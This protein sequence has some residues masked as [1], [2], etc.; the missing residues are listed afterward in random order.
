[1]VR[2][3]FT[4]S[5]EFLPAT[6]TFWCRPT[7]DFE[8]VTA[9]RSQFAAHSQVALAVAD[10]EAEDL[11]LLLPYTRKGTPGISVCREEWDAESIFEVGYFQADTYEKD[12][13][14]TRCANLRCRVVWGNSIIFRLVGEF[15]PNGTDI[16]K[17]DCVRAAQE[18]VRF[19]NLEVNTRTPW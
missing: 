6:L 4:A 5:A 3:S 7:E 11:P 9:A 19:L 18:F 15:Q 13:C 1:M 17:S 2:K 14:F 16:N 12:L 10:V 8:R